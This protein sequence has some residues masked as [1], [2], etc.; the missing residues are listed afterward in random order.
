MA[1]RN[2]AGGTPPGKHRAAG[3]AGKELNETP[4]RFDLPRESR[5]EKLA[6]APVDQKQASY[7]PGAPIK[8]HVKRMNSA[9]DEKAESDR[10]AARRSLRQPPRPR[11]GVSVTGFLS[12]VIILYV[13]IAYFL[14][15]PSD[16]SRER[17]VCRK[18]DGFSS[19]LHSYEP[20]FRPYYR[21]AQKKVEPYVR[22]TK[23]VA[24]PYVDQV[25]PYYSRVDKTVSPRVHQIYRFYLRSVYPRLVAAVRNIR[26]RTRP[27]ALK[28]EREYKKTL[29]P[30]VD[31]YSKSLREW[32]AAKVEPSLSQALL[33]GRQYFGTVAET[34]SPLYTRGIPLARHHYR[35]HLVPFARSSYSTT[36]RTYF[37]HV[38]PR[39]A[40]GTF[41]VQR[42]Y[43]S[44]VSPS[45]SRFWSKFIAP[46]LDKIKERIFEFKAKEARVAAM[47]RVEK[48]A[49]EIAHEHGEEDFED[50]VKELRDDTYV[51]ETAS[52]IVEE[53]VPPPS[54]STAVPP[55][56]SPEEQAVITAEKR[57]AL[58]RLQ[59]TYEREIA[60][61]GQTEQRLLVQRLADIRRQALEDIPARFDPVL[62]SLDEEGDTMVGK[63][64]RYFNKVSS[65]DKT[66]TENK[67]K[68]SEKLSEK[69][70]VRVN[71]MKQ[72]VEDEIEQ[73]RRSLIVKEEAAVDEA[74]TSLTTLVSKAQEELGFG[75]TWLDDV[76]HRDW[77]RYHGLRKAEENLHTSFTSLQSGEI[78]DS[79]LS[80]LDP[81]AL[82]DKY[83]A[84]PEA[85]VSSF[86]AILAKI[87]IKG[88]KELMGEWA[89]VTHEA[90][91]V[92]EAVGDKVA[93]AVENVK[94]QASSV[95]GVEPEPTNLRETMAAL[96]SSAQLSA[97]S[98][99][100]ALPTIK[101]P[102]SPSNLRQSAG[103]IVSE[104]QYRAA[105]AYAR[106]SQDGLR[107][108]GLEPSPTDLAQSAA[109]VT[110]A[111]RS[112]ASSLVEGAKQQAHEAFGDVSQA[113]VRAVG[114]EPAPTNL[115][116]SATSL[117][118]VASSV[119]S[120]ATDVASSLVQP[121]SD[122][123]K[124]A[125]VLPTARSIAG[126]GAIKAS[127]DS[128]ARSASSALHDA[129]RTTAEGFAETASSLVAAATDSI[130]SLASPH[131]SYSK[132][133][134]AASIRSIVHEATETV[135]SVT[136]QA[137]SVAR[138]ATE[139][140][141]TALH[142]EL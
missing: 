38:H 136:S 7:S 111:A 109:S 105:E 74:K 32:Y 88:Q 9:I 108:V 4:A 126:G 115:Q 104:A 129:T 27:L 80:S 36:R 64:G 99:A 120:S 61:L 58:E 100:A 79:T 67:V 21:T 116:Q 114:G 95:V 70:K 14:V 30:S 16:P 69:A 77:Q 51:G 17:A 12:R 125:P 2:S 132:S 29:A 33:A 113:V 1:P 60:T 47:K 76:K 10:R 23:R 59:S 3:A 40:T 138:D 123:A 85:L 90:Q 44:K 50:F 46:Q 83:A 122:F 20:T 134:A 84:Q 92:Y 81:Y 78:R 25:K 28:V 128:L 35:T 63:L 18:F 34:V 82:L 5:E 107:A 65:D 91:K 139:G 97:S 6:L 127:L 141:K 41:H 8:F 66:T 54:Y 101:T 56:P 26:S 13:A 43:K 89:G 31:W 110:Q 135:A 45:L 48:V 57:A 94:E 112:S 121:H 73:Y 137:K 39:L 19:T 37:S 131:P 140:V 86:V 106:A 87:A 118:G 98:L 93:A 24:Q 102:H 96:A 142:V 119:F 11:K 117:V 42:L 62:E 103:F 75:W 15:C 130:D 55:P 52:P 71:K 68:G 53:A 72:K 133:T 124:S 49:D 22:E